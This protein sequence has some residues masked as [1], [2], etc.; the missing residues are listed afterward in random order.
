MD[1]DPTRRVDRLALAS[2]GRV[3]VP[4]EV[5]DRADFFTEYERARARLT[6]PRGSVTTAWV[7]CPVLLSWRPIAIQARVEREKVLRFIKLDPFA[8]PPILFVML[9]TGLYCWDGHHR[10][11]AAWARRDACVLGRVRDL[12]PREPGG[13]KLSLDGILEEEGRGVRAGDQ[14]HR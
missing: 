11:T 1:A 7:T 14:P 10:L 12:V 13:G 2:G 3:H 9:A 4:F 6:D 5:A 8:V